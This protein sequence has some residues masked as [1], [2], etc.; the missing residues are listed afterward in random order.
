MNAFFALLSTA[1]VIASSTN[2]PTSRPTSHAEQTASVTVGKCT[3]DPNYQR[4]AFWIGDW[5]VLDS[6]GAH[7]ATQR[8]HPVLDD[9]ALTAEWIGPAGGT[10]L[11]FFAF[12]GKP[13]EW[14]QMYASN[15][16]PMPMGVKIRRSDPS[17]TGQGIRLIPTGDDASAS[18]QTRVTIR[19]TEEK[20]V[21]EEF[22]DSSDG[23]KTWH[24]VFSGVHRL[25]SK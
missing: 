20:R 14:K 11:G 8:V 19:P 1:L 22:E 25:Q 10:G 4:L 24:L 17:Y 18:M 9:C 21:V 23:G 16:V 13:G 7:Y 3:D 6:A 5:D 15:Q 2:S 12:D